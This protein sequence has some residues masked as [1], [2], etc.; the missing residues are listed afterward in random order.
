MHRLAVEQDLAG[1]RDDGTGQRLDQRRLARAVV[2]DDRQHLPRAQLEVGTG[3]R[4]H[5]AIAL[6]EPRGLEDGRGGLGLRPGGAFGP[7]PGVGFARGRHFCLM[8]VSWSTETATMTRMPVIR[9]W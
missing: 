3:E 6:H 7:R 2:T 4:G 8:R 5:V 1:V 9:T